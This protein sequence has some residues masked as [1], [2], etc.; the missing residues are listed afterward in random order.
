MSHCVR[1]LS[2]LVLLGG[3][4]ARADDPSRLPDV[5]A[6]Q[7]AMQKAIERAEPSIACIMVSRGD[8]KDK[9]EPEKPNFVPGIYGSGVLIDTQGLVLTN[10]HVIRGA[11]GIYVRLPGDKASHDL[12]RRPAQRPCRVET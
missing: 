11:N 3:A 9:F 8:D 5:T 10:E 6:L 2:L 7:A 12:G 1:A 4:F